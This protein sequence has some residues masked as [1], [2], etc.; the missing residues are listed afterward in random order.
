MFDA[1]KCL[2]EQLEDPQKFMEFN[3]LL[4]RIPFVEE[5]VT[6]MKEY[7]TAMEPV[8]ACLDNLQAE[9]KAYLGMFLP[10]L[11]IMKLKL[12]NLQSDG[13]LR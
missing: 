9:E 2:L 13:N 10:S 5:D 4:Q 6:I 7:V 12:E 1:L 8:A 11:F 3:E